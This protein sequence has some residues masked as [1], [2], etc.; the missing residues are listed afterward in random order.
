MVAE[1]QPTV[2]I[3]R[4]LSA[5]GSPGVDGLLAGL[6]RRLYLVKFPLVVCKT[7]PLLVDK[8]IEIV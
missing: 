2:T 1:P 6:G 7:L 4:G 5:G 3:R 8:F